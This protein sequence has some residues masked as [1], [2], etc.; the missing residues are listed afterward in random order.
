MSK[1][2]AFVGDIHGNI[3]ALNGMLFSLKEASIEHVV[4]LGDYLNKGND[5]APVLDAL[6]SRQG[7][8]DVTLLLGNHELA[9]L[10]AFDTRDLG[11]FLK[12]GG[13]GTI[14][15]Y[16]GGDV[17]ADVYSEF[18]SNFPQTHLDG[19]RLMPSRWESEELMVQH[20]P[21]DYV[22][23]KFVISAHVPVG[24]LPK[25]TESSAQIDTGCSGINPDGRL[26][27]FLWPSK[28]FIQVENDG[29]EIA[30][31]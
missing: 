21:A 22:G 12:M 5:S 2:I 10:K 16:L 3:R 30:L 18:Y 27:A 1:Q 4:F 26:T 14:R 20:E 13:A 6:L 9:L 7:S 25:M 17:G 28:A 23:P 31:E 11:P 24:S 19:L 8:G 29:S 15:S